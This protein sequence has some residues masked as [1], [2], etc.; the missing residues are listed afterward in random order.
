MSKFVAG[1]GVHCICLNT[2]REGERVKGES[3]ELCRFRRT[4]SVTFASTKCGLLL[5]TFE[6][7]LGDVYDA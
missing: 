6:W 2:G 3:V 1:A 5:C 4:L 7:P